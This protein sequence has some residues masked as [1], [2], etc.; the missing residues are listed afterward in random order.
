MVPR[1]VRATRTTGKPKYFKEIHHEIGIIEGNQHP[2]R[3]LDNQPLRLRDPMAFWIASSRN[4]NAHST[5]PPSAASRLRQEPRLRNFILQAGERRRIMRTMYDLR[6]LARTGLNR[7]PVHPVE[8]RAHKSAET[9]VFPAP[10][11]VPVTNNLFIRVPKLWPVGRAARALGKSRVAKAGIYLP[12]LAWPSRR[13]GAARAA[14]AGTEGGRMARTVK[15]AFLKALSVAPPPKW[16]APRI[17]GYDLRITRPGVESGSFEVVPAQK[18]VVARSLTCCRNDLS[19][20]PLRRISATGS[21]PGSK[22]PRA[23]I[24]E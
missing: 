21:A 24:E 19:D 9:M 22:Q 6:S 3:T 7:L 4:L 2:A 11:S 18:A 12:A 16:L 13:Q 1:A 20:R 15:A 5:L 8:R 17:T 14:P 23:S 10:V